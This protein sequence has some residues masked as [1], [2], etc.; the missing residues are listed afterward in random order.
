MW[1]LCFCIASNKWSFKTEWWG[2]D[3]QQTSSSTE[4][5][6]WVSNYRDILLQEGPII[7]SSNPKSAMRKLLWVLQNRLWAT[8]EGQAKVAVER[9]PSEAKRVGSQ[10]CLWTSFVRGT[11]ASP[12]HV[13]FNGFL[14]FFPSFTQIYSSSSLYTLYQFYWGW[15]WR[16]FEQG[17]CHCQNQRQNYFFK[18]PE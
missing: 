1:S 3:W 18:L 17:D 10:H 7:P 14:S 9:G 8:Q 2:A 13:L 12:S 4:Q 6:L 15:M 11:T 5:P 16:W